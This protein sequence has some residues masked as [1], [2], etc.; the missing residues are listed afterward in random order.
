L[1]HLKLHDEYPAA[2]SPFFYVALFLMIAAACVTFAL[3]KGGSWIWGTL[4]LII[5]LLLGAFVRS[6]ANPLLMKRV[7]YESGLL[8]PAILVNN[9]PLELIAMAD[10][11]AEEDRDAV[12]G[13]V[14]IKVNTL[15]NHQIKVGEKVPCVA[16]FGMANG[17]YRRNFEPRPVA[18]G[19]KDANVI[20]QAIESVAVDGAPDDTDFQDEWEMLHAL[21]PKMATAQYNEIRFF[22]PNLEATTL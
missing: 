6:Y 5:T 22:D 11:R 16:L 18:W 1:D 20:R 14:K 7:A 4:A 12:F 8:V 3:Y 13:C 21:V 15:P 9:E 17:G 2:R 19:Y 10:M